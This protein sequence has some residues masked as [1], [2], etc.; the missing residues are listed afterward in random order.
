MDGDQLLEAGGSP[1]FDFDAGHCPQLLLNFQKVYPV[2]Q[3]KAVG[4]FQDADLLDID[5]HWMAFEPLKPSAHY[6]LTIIGVLFF[7]LGFFSNAL[8][9]CTI[10]R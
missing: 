8:V 6:T 2:E 7:L 3:W 9:I 10:A 1:S 4:F 5:C